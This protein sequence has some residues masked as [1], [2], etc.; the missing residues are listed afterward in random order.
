MR[1][2]IDEAPAALAV[3]VG[4][5]QQE[6]CTGIA[7]GKRTA[8]TKGEV[9]VILIGEWIG[10]MKA[11]PIKPELQRV[12]S[13]DFGQRGGDGVIVVSRRQEPGAD[14]AEA[15]GDTG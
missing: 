2:R 1:A 8:A 12:P 13:V 7:R 14:G 3:G 15:G 4:N 10:N 6:V 9:A 5:S 11:A